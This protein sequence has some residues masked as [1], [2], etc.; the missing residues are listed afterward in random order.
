MVIEVDNERSNTLVTQNFV[1]SM[2]EIRTRPE[3]ILRIKL[4]VKNYLFP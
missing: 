1:L 4:W 3:A 2:L